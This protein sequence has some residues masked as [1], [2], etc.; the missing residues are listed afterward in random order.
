[1]STIII[2]ISV[3]IIFIIIIIIIFYY[4]YMSCCSV[5]EDVAK[6]TRAH[7]CPESVYNKRGKCND[8]TFSQCKYVHFK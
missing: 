7:A 1:M 8:K 5:F 6:Q 2:I 3:I 4:V